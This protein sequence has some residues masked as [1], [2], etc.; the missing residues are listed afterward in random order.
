MRKIL[1]AVA[2]LLSI[3]TL[4]LSFPVSATEQRV[5]IPA[6]FPGIGDLRA[7]SRVLC[8]PAEGCVLTE[9]D[10]SDFD[11]EFFAES[12]SLGVYVF[13]FP[14]F[15][16]AFRFIDTVATNENI[17]KTEIS[18]SYI[19][20][21]ISD[22]HFEGDEFVFDGYWAFDEDSH[23][24]YYYI[25]EDVEVTRVKIPDIREIIAAENATFETLRY[26]SVCNEE[27]VGISDVILLSKHVYGKLTLDPDSQEYKNAN[28]DL[29]SDA[30]DASDLKALID[31]LIGKVESLPVRG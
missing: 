3:A 4:S 10:F 13:D 9:E 8:T 16:E 6:T 15:N 12:P 27:T 18:N 20:M 21:F 23:Q 25:P 31:F 22:V 17:V 29:R 5:L 19:S 7:T 11:I 30:V 14:T 28:C 26:G 24:K 1:K 2:V